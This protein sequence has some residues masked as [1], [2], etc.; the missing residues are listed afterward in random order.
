MKPSRRIS[1]LTCFLIIGHSLPAH[2]I[3]LDES[4]SGRSSGQ[5]EYFNSNR[6]RRMMIQVNILSGV[7]RPGLHQVPDN[8]NIVDA[9]A[10]AGGLSAE[11]DF[12]K[13][14]V[15]RKVAGDKPRYQTLEYDLTE[16]VQDDRSAYPMLQNND[17]VLIEPR[18]KTDQRLLTFLTILAS[19]VGIVS[20]VV[21]VNKALKD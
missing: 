4:F 1:L 3:N 8:T 9:L 13:V 10:L 6:E 2:A 20:G 16:L 15:K 18:S 21:L 7:A 12:E 11:A 14:F 5:A 19:T 17:T